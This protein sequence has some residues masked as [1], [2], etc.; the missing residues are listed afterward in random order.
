MI[1]C[2]GAAGVVEAAY[3]YEANHQ[4]RED[5]PKPSRH[6]ALEAS[7]FRACPMPIGSRRDAVD[8]RTAAIASEVRVH[9]SVGQSR[10]ASDAAFNH[11]VVSHLAS[12]PANV[13]LIRV[14]SG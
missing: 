13:P 11:R 12:P 10:I 4:R 8:D 6:V 14:S 5:D 3:G 9:A 1:V 2:P 7:P